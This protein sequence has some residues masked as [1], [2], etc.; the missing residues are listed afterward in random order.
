[1]T[2]EATP[3][4]VGLSEESERA[5]FEAWMSSDGKWPNAVE[6]SIGGGYKLGVTE[7]A[8]GVWKAAVAHQREACAKLCEALPIIGSS[9]VEAFGY[10]NAQKDC[11]SAIRGPNVRANRLAPEKG[12][13]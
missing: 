1:M 12:N 4:E 5:A 2:N 6:R 9:D 3:R 8:W 10:S 11:A 7:H 13:E